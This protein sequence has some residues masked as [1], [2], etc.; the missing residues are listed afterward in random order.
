MKILLRQF[1]VTPDNKKVYD[2]K[3]I[4]AWD[5]NTNFGFD[6]NNPKQW[7]VYLSKLRINGRFLPRACSLGI[8]YRYRVYTFGNPKNV[9]TYFPGKD[10]TDPVKSKFLI[11]THG[12]LI[13]LEKI[14]K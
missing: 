7:W 6:V 12:K 9:V 11:S 10:K 8:E 1:K 13:P 4:H 14:L 5:S 2:G 3:K